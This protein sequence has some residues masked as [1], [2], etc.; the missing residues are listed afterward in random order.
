MIRPIC[1]DVLILSRKSEPAV[2]EDAET[3]RDLMDTLAAHKDECIGMAANMIGV[4][5]C[6]IAVSMGFTNV[7]MIN[8]VIT[9]KEEPYDAEEGCLSLSGTRKVTRYKSIEVEY[10]D[11]SFKQHKQKFS[12]LIAQIIQHECDHL[13][14]ILI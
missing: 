5:K 9:T 13:E 2:Q 11:E 7:A 14:G 4:N 8:P 12:G 1:R 3:V 10:S 6:I